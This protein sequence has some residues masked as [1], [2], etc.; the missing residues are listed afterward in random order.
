[1]GTRVHQ[2]VS[3]YSSAPLVLS[4]PMTFR[5]FLTPDAVVATY[6][7][8][9]RRSGGG[10]KLVQRGLAGQ[11]SDYRRHTRLAEALRR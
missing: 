4:A 8:T 11:D 3:S 1:M 9:C 2:L 10:S 7:I 6:P 5:S